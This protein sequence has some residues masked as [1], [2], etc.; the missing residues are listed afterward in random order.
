MFVASD[1]IY[2]IIMVREEVFINLHGIYKMS[3]PGKIDIPVFLPLLALPLRSC[4]GRKS[5]GEVTAI[6]IEP[7]SKSLIEST[8][9]KQPFIFRQLRYEPR[10]WARDDSAGLAL[11]EPADVTMATLPA[12][13]PVARYARAARM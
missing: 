4:Q 1:F 13:V 10:H 3:L 2:Q 8:R 7:K 9:Q 11:C 5:L 6:L 12:F